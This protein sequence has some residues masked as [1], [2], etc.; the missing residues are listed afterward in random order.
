VKKFVRGTLLEPNKVSAFGFK[1]D[2]F[3][4]TNIRHRI[5]RL[6]DRCGVIFHVQAADFC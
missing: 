3:A 1:K 2:H 4:R 6:A 5:V